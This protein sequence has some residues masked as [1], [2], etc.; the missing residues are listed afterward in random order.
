VSDDQ[1][2]NVEVRAYT[3]HGDVIACDELVT[4]PTAVKPTLQNA[5]DHAL[6]DLRE[7]GLL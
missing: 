1:V 7:R 4:G 5:V 3:K 2:V 6:D